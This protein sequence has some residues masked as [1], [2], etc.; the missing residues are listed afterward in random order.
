MEILPKPVGVMT[1]SGVSPLAQTVSVTLS[2]LASGFSGLVVGETYYTTTR[3]QVV[4]DGSYYGSGDTTASNTGLNGFF[5]ANDITDNIL[6]ST[7]SI[8]GM[9]VASDTILLKTV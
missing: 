2:G 7:D 5:Y 4:T 9:A 8:L 3:G 6:V 1:S